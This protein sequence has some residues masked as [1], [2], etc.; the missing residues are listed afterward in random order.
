M[1][2]NNPPSIP[3]LC[4][5]EREA[6]RLLGNISRATLAN[7]RKAA[8]LPFIKLPGRVM[9]SPTDLAA[10][11]ESRKVRNTKQIEVI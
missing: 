4:V 1:P 8:G 10:W 9:F 5:D 2:P 3:P 11:L 6:R 7:Y